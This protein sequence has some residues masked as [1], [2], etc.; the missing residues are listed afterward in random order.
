MSKHTPGPWAAGPCC[1]ISGW[2]EIEADAPGAVIA[3]ARNQ[4]DEVNIANAR[5]IASAPQMLEALED[6][7]DYFHDIPE[8][9]VGGDDE[10][11]RIASVIRAAIAAAKGTP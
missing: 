8:S 3:S 7:A 4:P 1:H 10:A 5:L 6:A 2:V 11:V 9:S